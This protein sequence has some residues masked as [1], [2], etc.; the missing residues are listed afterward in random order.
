MIESFYRAFEDKYRGSRDLIKSRLR[1]YLP[2]VLPL[3]EI[4]PDCAAVDI[5]CGR[6]EWLEVLSENGFKAKGID[7]DDGMLQACRD[8]GLN[9]E[10]ADALSFLKNLPDQSQVVVSGFHIAEH[11]LFDELLQI[12]LE[13]KRILSPGGLLILETP[14]PE[15]LYV[16]S[17]LFYL[18]PTHVNPLPY[19]LLSFLP[20]FCGY[21]RVKVIRMQQ[22]TRIFQDQDFKL[23]DVIKGVSPDYAVIAQAIPLDEPLQLLEA[24]FLD[25]SQSGFSLE[26]ISA[27]YQE[28]VLD[29][30]Q[31]AELKAEQAD[32]KA[33]KAIT[34]ALKAT[35]I[36]ESITFTS[37]LQSLF[38]KIFRKFS[39]FK[40]RK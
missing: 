12:V 31:Q 20:E 2:F 6:G 29:A 27:L 28:K 34:S 30:I 35:W 26:Q 25:E 7:L 21:D 40:N 11:L 18:D 17:S 22:D 24:A 5:G 1:V 38:M 37:L 3:Q 23:I 8:L 15:N 36:V 14:N 16:G 32:L 10:H 4:Y 9:V 33:Q 13:A 39:R 19:Q